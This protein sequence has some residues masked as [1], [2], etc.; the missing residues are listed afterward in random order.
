MAEDVKECFAGQYA[1]EG[2][3]AEEAKRM[4]LENPD[5]YV[6]KPQ[7][8]GGGNNLYGQDIAHA[9]RNGEGLE[10]YVLMDRIRPPRQPCLMLRSGEPKLVDSVSEL[11]MFSVFFRRSGGSSKCRCVGHLMRTKEADADE[12]GVVAGY[13]VLDSPLLV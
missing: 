4:A 9:I 5:G 8:E 10:Q 2:E 3:N 11:G 13:G 7:R 12:G 1:L 6:L